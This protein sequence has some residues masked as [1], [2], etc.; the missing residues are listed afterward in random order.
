MESPRKRVLSVSDTEGKLTKVT[1]TVLIPS[2][3]SWDGFLG[4]LGSFLQASVDLAPESR[5]VSELPDTVMVGKDA[6]DGMLAVAVRYSKPERA[7]LELT[8]KAIQ[9]ADEAEFT[10]HLG[11]REEGKTD[12][13]EAQDK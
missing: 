1:L 11:P 7:D 9:M 13:G 3:F 10:N 8:V 2:E 5:L 12:G 6:D 4:M